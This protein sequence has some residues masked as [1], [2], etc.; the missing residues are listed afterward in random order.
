MRLLLDT[1][2][3]YW[4][5]AGDA[6]LSATARKLIQDE[7]NEVLISPVSYWEIAI[8]VS[9]GKWKLNRTYEELIDVAL[10]QYRFGVLPI[11]PTHTAKVIELPFHH[12]DPFDRLLIAQALA[13]NLSIVAND[14]ALDAYGVTRLW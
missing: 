6:Q 12:K 4:Y 7:A 14:P 5:I 9:L 1:H 8:K 11:L 10:I 3:M 2:A 13:E